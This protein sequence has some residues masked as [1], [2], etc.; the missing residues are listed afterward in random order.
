[1]EWPMPPILGG[2]FPLPATPSEVKQWALIKW[3][4][5]MNKTVIDGGILVYET[6]LQQACQHVQSWPRIVW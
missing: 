6:V 4:D 1:M 3:Y 5:T 2:R